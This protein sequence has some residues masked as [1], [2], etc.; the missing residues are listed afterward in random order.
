[1]SQ[2]VTIPVGATTAWQGLFDYENQQAGQRLLILGGAGGVGLYTVQFAHW[3]E[4]H[5]ITLYE[6]KP[7]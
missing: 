4:A 7:E 3:K 6:R 1:M 5:V 2:V